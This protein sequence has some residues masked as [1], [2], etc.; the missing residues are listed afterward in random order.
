MPR[1]GGREGRR[2]R[3]RR[4]APAI[5]ESATTSGGVPL[6]SRQKFVGTDLHDVKRGREEGE[7]SCV[8][9]LAG[10]DDDAPCPVREGGWLSSVLRYLEA[11]ERKTEG[12][13]AR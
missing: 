6:T 13:I 1:T 12:A 3:R 7:Y 11:G 5:R 8:R 2:R 9:I 10:R 4:N